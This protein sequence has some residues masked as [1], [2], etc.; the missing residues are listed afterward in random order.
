M[1]IVRNARSRRST[2]WGDASDANGGAVLGL[3]GRG[4]NHPYSLAGIARGPTQTFRDPGIACARNAGG[5]EGH[6]RDQRDA[7]GRNRSAEEQAA[8]AKARLK[9]ALQEAMRA[10]DELTELTG[11]IHHID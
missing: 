7:Q 3:D 6:S 9:E 2:F 4:I 11:S 10:A 8:S 1:D 5:G